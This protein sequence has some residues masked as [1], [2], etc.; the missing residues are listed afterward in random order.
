MT[1]KKNVIKHS[2]VIQI[3]HKI[4]L[5]EQHL[6]NALL[7]EAFDDLKTN[8]IHSVNIDLL[9]EYVPGI[10]SVKNL[11]KMLK[12]LR[13]TSVEYNIFE[14][15]REKEW[16]YLS[17]LA[18]VRIGK[19]NKI[20]YFSFAPELIPALSDPRIYS[21]INLKL[22]K[23]YKGGQYG[24]ALYELCWDYKTT[25]SSSPETGRTPLSTITKLK[26]YFGIRSEIYK[27]YKSFNRRVLQPAIKEVNEQTDIFIKPETKKKGQAIHS[28]IFYITKN[29]KFKKFLSLQADEIAIPVQQIPFEKTGIE[30]I[31]KELKIAGKAIKALREQYTDE[32]IEEALE[33]CRE[34]EDRGS[35]IARPGAYLKK[36]LS[37]MSNTPHFQEPPEDKESIAMEEAAKKDADLKL[38]QGSTNEERFDELYRRQPPIFKYNYDELSEEKKKQ[39]KEEFEALFTLNK[40]FEDVHSEW[41]K[42]LDSIMSFNKKKQ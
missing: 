10:N 32:K 21:K 25:I 13:D 39:F 38:Y 17:L 5:L 16:G 9:K 29:P 27:E 8:P 22:Q 4:S 35:V 31:L 14:K 37:D 15:D 6:F 34:N 42:L 41:G 36:V 28:I 20:C 18:G 19:F 24:W 2:A 23:E 26:N 11:K 40:N 7:T 3:S 12:N 30:K 1:T 33:I